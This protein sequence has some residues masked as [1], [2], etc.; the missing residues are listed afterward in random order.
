MRG[1]EQPQFEYQSAEPDAAHGERG[2]DRQGEAP[3][4]VRCPGIAVRYVELKH[5]APPIRAQSVV[6]RTGTR[7]R[8]GNDGTRKLITLR[9]DYCSER[10]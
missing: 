3:A 6:S 1:A 2:L 8:E 4:E 7:M 9:S 5:F 10:V